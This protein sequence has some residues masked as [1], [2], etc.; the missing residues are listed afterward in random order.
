VTAARGGGEGKVTSPSDHDSVRIRARG[1]GTRGG[2]MG[3]AAA[4]A[5]DWHG[6]AVTGP[7]QRGHAHAH[8][9]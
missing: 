9:D 4:V 5:G 2:G 7:R 8:S 3:P 6:E 1:G